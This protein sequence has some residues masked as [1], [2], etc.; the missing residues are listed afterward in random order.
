MSA[1]LA[2]LRELLR[3]TPPP[4][5]SLD[6]T[7]APAAATVVLPRSAGRPLLFNSGRWMLDGYVWWMLDGYVVDVG[8]LRVG[9]VGW[10]RVASVEYV[11]WC[12]GC[13]HCVFQ[14]RRSSP[15]F[16]PLVQVFVHAA[17]FWGCL[18]Q[19]SG[20]EAREARLLSCELTGVF[21]LCGLSPQLKCRA[22]ARGESGRHP[23][24]G[25]RPEPCADRNGLP[26]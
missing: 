13:V 16:V 6:S 18:F 4:I 21:D 8:W 26:R 23:A 9:H 24:A 25:A 2:V 20:V 5:P 14:P 3:A 19:L 1:N 15:Y 22:A 12:A 7:A 11:G 17:Y 10:S